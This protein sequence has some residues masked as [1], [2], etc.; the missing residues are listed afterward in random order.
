MP[1]MKTKTIG[2]IGGGRITRILLQAFQNKDVSFDN[3]VVHDHNTETAANLKRQFSEIMV[4]GPED[5]ASQEI[6]IIALHP[7]VI[8]E[9]LD[10]IKP[11]VSLEATLISLAPK[12]T[13]GKI[14]EKLGNVSRI[15]RLIPNATS[16]INEGY[17]PVS[18]SS[19][20]QDSDKQSL[21]QTLGVLGDTFEVEEPKLE[22]YAIISAM[23]PTYFWFQ[24]K[25]LCDIGEQIGLDR[26]ASEQAVSH[27]MNAAL[28]TMFGSGL[29]WDEVADLIPVKPIG[30]HEQEIMNMY[31]QKL[32]GLHNKI[33]P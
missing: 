3:I 11:S 6:V 25:R 15:V 27:T 1:T 10:K 5:A 21:M 17:N 31:D 32:V 9:M 19:G 24:W 20:L 30:E 18:F 33:S 29:S 12:I 8:M 23:A 16:I 26:E 13:I 2:F 28:N 4:S 14:S 7:P 22:A